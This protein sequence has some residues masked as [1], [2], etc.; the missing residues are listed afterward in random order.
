MPYT[1]LH[2]DCT[3]CDNWEVQGA[4]DSRRHL[5][6]FTYDY[7]TEI[8]TC[9]DCCARATSEYLDSEED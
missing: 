5:T 1:N 6:C 3:K 9:D 2:V 4:D 7:N 8:Y